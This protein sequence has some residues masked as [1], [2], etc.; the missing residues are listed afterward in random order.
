MKL[1]YCSPAPTGK[2]NRPPGAS[3]WSKAGGTCVPAGR[4]TGNGPENA[5]YRQHLRALFN[6][7]VLEN[8]LKW[9]AWHGA[10]GPSYSRENTRAA[11]TGA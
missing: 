8:D 2:T 5:T 1:R 11:S 7:A 10:Y 4:L 9:N 3:C 6:C